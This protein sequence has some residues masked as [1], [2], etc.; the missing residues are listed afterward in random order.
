MS[1]VTPPQ[2]HTAS[3]RLKATGTTILLIHIPTYSNV[4]SG[5]KVEVVGTLYRLLQP[6]TF[7]LCWSHFSAPSYLVLRCCV[8]THTYLFN[9]SVCIVSSVSRPVFYSSVPMTFWSQSK[10]A[11]QMWWLLCH[12]AEAMENHYT[13]ELEDMETWWKLE[14]PGTMLHN[15]I[16]AA[17][18][19]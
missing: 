3:K 17:N 15:K 14:E 5:S 2:T 8:D 10:P 11:G 16:K 13:S 1:E 4:E 6:Y 7:L 19:N 9:R 12:C 18:E